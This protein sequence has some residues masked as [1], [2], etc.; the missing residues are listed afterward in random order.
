M[1]LYHWVKNPRSLFFSQPMV[2]YL[3][4]L[5]KKTHNLLLHKLRAL[6]AEIIHADFREVVINTKKA[7]WEQ[8]QSMVEFVCS[9][10]KLAPW[11]GLLGLDPSKYWARLVWM[12][13]YNFAGLE[14]GS[15]EA[16]GPLSNSLTDAELLRQGLVLRSEWEFGEHLPKKHR[17]VMVVSRCFRSRTRLVFSQGF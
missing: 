4:R 2:R 10:V 3:H 6:G 1:N 7:Q 11:G 8:A 15:E 5:M 17:Q 12:D 14:D 13:R 9:E 16:E